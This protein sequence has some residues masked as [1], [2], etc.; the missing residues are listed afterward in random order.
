MALG[1]LFGQLLNKSAQ[2][3]K[4]ALP[5]AQK[6]AVPLAVAGGTAAGLAG[7]GALGKVGMDV[8]QGDRRATGSSPITGEG[9]GMTPAQINDLYRMAAN[10]PA[11]QA[12]QILPTIQALE[13]SRLQN[14]MEATRQVGQ[15][16]GDLARQKYGFQLAG[17]AQQTGLGTLQALMQNPNP[18]AQT[19]LSG[20]TNLSL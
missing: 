6:A 16:Q 10:L 13:N 11:E 9:P 15:I 3:G 5:I 14:S 12:A 8:I 18:Y 7:L 1:Q 17:Q 4:A 19:G 20:V 2:V